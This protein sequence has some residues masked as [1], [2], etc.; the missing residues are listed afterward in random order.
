VL[1]RARGAGIVA[2]LDLAKFA[3][4]LGD[5]LLVCVT[6]TASRAQIDALAR[7]L[8]GAKS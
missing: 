7:V 3:P 4:E 6:E 5:A 2:G 8:A 1:A